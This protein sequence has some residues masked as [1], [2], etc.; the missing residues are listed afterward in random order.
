MPDDVPGALKR[1]PTSGRGTAKR[2]ALAEARTCVGEINRHLESARVQLLELYEREGW[3]A[4]GYGSWRECVMAEFH[5]SQSA[6]YRALE[7]ARVEQELFPTLGKVSLDE[8]HLVALAPLPVKEQRQLA[9]RVD[10]AALSVR[11][12]RELVAAPAAVRLEVMR[13][14]TA[15]ADRRELRALMRQTS[16]QLALAG[17]RPTVQMEQAPRR[18]LDN[19]DVR[20][21]VVDPARIG[22]ADGAFDLVVESPPFALDIPYADGGDV[23]DYPTYRHCMTAWS[24]ELYRVSNP[25]HGRVCIEIPLDRSKDGVY[26]PVY[27]DWVQALRGAGFKYRTTFLRRYH[28]GRGTARGSVDSPSATHTFAP[29]LA[30]IVA[31][32]G[33]WIRRSDRAHD[34]E[35]EDWLALAGPNGN[36][37]DIPG[38]ADTEHPAPFHIEVPRRLIKLYSYRDDLVGDLFLG[39]GTTALACVEL[40]RRFRGGD[41]SANYV[42][43]AEERVAAALD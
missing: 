27:S 33:T 39:R 24:A 6:L 3:R 8:S 25:D 30:I 7:A 20:I 35:H 5:R 4:L 42:A 17:A 31:Y 13:S 23:P 40:G 2:M 10:L 29:V 11:L 34:L 15:G 26:E 43:I 37:D 19:D 22:V 16:A 28:A 32:R 12:V 38:E 9:T 1:D 21:D 41:R 36:W 14:A 18:R